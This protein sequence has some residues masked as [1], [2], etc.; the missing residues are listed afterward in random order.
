[1]LLAI[2]TATRFTSLALYDGRDILA[3][4]TWLNPSGHSE[5]LAPMLRDMLAYTGVNL[6]ALAGMAVSVGP[7]SYTGLRV[8]VALA[9]GMADARRLPLV[10]L[11]TLETLAAAYPPPSNPADLIAVVQ[12]GRGRVI[13]QTFR[14]RKTA[15]VSRTE[16][17]LTD[18]D[19][20]LGGI[21][22]P[23]IVTGEIDAGGFD[24]LTDAASAGTPLHVA[25]STYRL[26]RASVLAELAW[27][28]LRQSDDHS[29]FQPDR[30]LPLYVK[31]EA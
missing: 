25:G 24:A 14:W 3:E 7:G 18:W 1:M 6:D 17:A 23:T 8:G 30:V 2:D 31:S 28:L 16:A 12:A 10:G 9:K 5:Q 27:E 21:S 15:W 19:A 4:H 29:A 20:L 22:D 26:R 11:S 13:A